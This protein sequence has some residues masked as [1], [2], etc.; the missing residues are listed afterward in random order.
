MLFCWGV[1]SSG[2][3]G[4]G[5]RGAS[6]PVPFR[7][8]P[9]AGPLGRAV[10]QV[11]CGERHTLLLLDDGS[12]AS[13]GD[14]DL[15]QLGRRLPREQQRSF[16]PGRFIGTEQQGNSGGGGGETSNGS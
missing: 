7:R 3:L 4:L 9:A 13:C 1:G 12:V 16:G 15:G 2:Q 8:G 14:N 6:E 5:K 11:A 10:A